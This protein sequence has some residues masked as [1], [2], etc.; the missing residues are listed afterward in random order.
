L[1]IDPWQIPFDLAL[2]QVLVAPELCMSVRRDPSA[3]A[4]AHK[5]LD[6]RGTPV[7]APIH[8]NNV[9]RADLPLA[10]LE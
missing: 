7:Q 8:D 2:P 6:R 4:S 1:D 9:A 5:P 10:I 3:L